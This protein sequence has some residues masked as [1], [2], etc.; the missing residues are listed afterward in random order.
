LWVILL[1]VSDEKFHVLLTTEERGKTIMKKGYSL[2]EPPPAEKDRNPASLEQR[3]YKM[4]NRLIATILKD[5]NF[6]KVITA[7]QK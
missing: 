7:P 1:S 4:T 6:Q 2:Q 3:I 5:P